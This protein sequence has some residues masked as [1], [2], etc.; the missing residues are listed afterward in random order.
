MDYLY[1]AYAKSVIS[2]DELE[3]C[4][5]LGFYVSN[6]QRIKILGIKSEWSDMFNI[7]SVVNNFIKKSGNIIQIKSVKSLEGYHADVYINK[8]G[9]SHSL[10]KLVNGWVENKLEQGKSKT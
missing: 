1:N 6:V 7:K 2:A 9:K 3:C 8:N 10:A 4:I 5:D